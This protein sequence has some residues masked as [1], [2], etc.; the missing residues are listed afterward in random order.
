MVHR[1]LVLSLLVIFILLGFGCDKAL[2]VKE[3]VQFIKN[4]DNGLKK[5]KKVGAI[6]ADLQFKPVPF[7]IA[8]ELRKH[9][10]NATEFNFRKKELQG[11]Q[12][13]NLQLGVDPSLNKNITTYNSNSLEDQQERLYYL[14]YQLKNDIRLIQGTDTLAPILYHFERTYDIS[15]HRTFVLAFEEKEYSS[16]LD[17]TL[18]IHSP[19][20]GTGPFKLKIK[21]SDLQNIPN[22]KLI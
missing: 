17:K 18:I 8:N 13:Y 6:I 5:Q 22:L 7:I 15:N 1:I 12:Y 9:N 3:Y 10:I 16:I 14:S 21:A 11:L 19:I 2:E 4:P 20:L